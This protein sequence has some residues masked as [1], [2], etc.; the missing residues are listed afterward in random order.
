MR[1]FKVSESA[2][3]PSA[4]TVHDQPDAD[5]T[6]QSSAD[7]REVAFQQCLVCLFTYFAHTLVLLLLLLLFFVSLFFFS[8]VLFFSVV[9]VTF[10]IIVPIIGA[11]SCKL[12]CLFYFVLLV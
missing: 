10:L 1:D 2:A 6:Q 8:S 7:Q 5:S 9:D 3:A 11:S 12:S 4:P